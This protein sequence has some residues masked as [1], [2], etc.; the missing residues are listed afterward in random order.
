MRRLPAG[1]FAFLLSFVALPARA[2][3]GFWTQLAPPALGYTVSV[4]DPVRDRFVI[5]LGWDGQKLCNDVWV[6]DAN[7]ATP[8]RKLAVAGTPPVQLQN[9][10]ISGAGYDSVRDRLLV[11]SERDAAGGLATTVYALTFSPSPAWSVV[12]TLGTQPSPRHGMSVVYDPVDDRL[13]A[14]GGFGPHPTLGDVTWNE[15]WALALGATPTWSL[16]S[17]G[18][19]LP[20]RRYD[21]GTVYDP[22]GHRMIVF[23]GVGDL[24]DTWALALSPNALA[25]SELPATNLPARRHGAALFV[26]PA[27]GILWMQGGLAGVTPRAD[28]WKVPLA[29]G[30]WTQVSP[31]QLP[32]ARGSWFFDS[33]RIRFV[34]Q[35][36]WKDNTIRPIDGT[37]ALDPHAASP[38]FALL[39]PAVRGCGPRGLAR[40]FHDPLHD[41]MVLWGGQGPVVGG[42]PTPLVYD[43]TGPGAWTDYVP[44]GTSIVPPLALDAKRAQLLGADASTGVVSVL[45]LAS[46]TWSARAASNSPQSGILTAVVDSIGDRLLVFGNGQEP[47]FGSPI[48]ATFAIPL[49]GANPAWT[50]IANVVGAPPQNSGSTAVYDPIARR[51]LWFGAG[52][53]VWELQLTGTPAWHQLPNFPIPIY[54]P[55]VGYD[56]PNHRILLFYARQQQTPDTWVYSWDLAQAGTAAVRQFPTGTAQPIRGVLWSGGFDPRRGQLFLTGGAD[57]MWVLNQGT[58]PAVGVDGSQATPSVSLRAFPVPSV[59]GVR[60]VWSTVRPGNVSLTIRDVRGRVV[61]ALVAESPTGVGEHVSTWDG[62]DDRGVRVAAGV[63]FGAL[64]SQAGSETRRI[65]LL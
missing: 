30:A 56:A 33:A 25:W 48:T 45:D 46:D 24:D 51:V 65:V 1:L 49:S 20:T 36:G 64:R 42:G 52:T 35:G 23:G 60:L 58:A 11:L 15:V 28:V 13:V 18:G 62:L 38:G 6:L 54:E 57:G 3:D 16:L 59:S 9:T 41:R 4:Y 39:G 47:V 21:A 37:W 27:N 14:Y 17:P 22:V 40:V 12:A 34:L 5:A 29:G 44:A 26:D 53:S 32:G 2:S 7:E 19:T 31:S 63:Y 43:R 50:G 8:W 10:T 61:R 55:A